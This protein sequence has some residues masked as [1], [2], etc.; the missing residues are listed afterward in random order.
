MLR[1]W[2]LIPPG[3]WIFVCCECCVLSGRV[4][5]DGVITRPEGVLPTVVR[6]YVWSRNLKNEVAVASVGPQ[7]HREKENKHKT[8]CA[9]MHPHCQ[10]VA[11]TVLTVWLHASCKVLGRYEV[12]KGRLKMI[13]VFWDAMP[14]KLAKRYEC[15]GDGCCLCSQGSR[16]RLTIPS[17]VPTHASTVICRLTS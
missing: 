5:C 10:P 6:R 2:V 3:A 11:R 4:L 9:L 17:L 7:R 1:S 12:L 14:G 16:R 8:A 13:S 15:F